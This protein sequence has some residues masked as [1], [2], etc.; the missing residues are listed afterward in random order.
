MEIRKRKLSKPF[1]LKIVQIVPEG[2]ITIA[3]ANK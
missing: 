3:Y 1:F 2:G